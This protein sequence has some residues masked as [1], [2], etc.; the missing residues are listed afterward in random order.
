MRPLAIVLGV[1]LVLFLIAAAIAIGE[2]D[3]KKNFL[4][5]LI[6]LHVIA[7]ICI[8]AAFLIIWGIHGITP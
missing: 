7:W 3:S 4:V 5:S 8:S 6:A 1:E 2:V